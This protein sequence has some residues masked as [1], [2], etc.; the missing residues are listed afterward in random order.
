MPLIFWLVSAGAGAL[1]W[2]A[3]DGFDAAGRATGTKEK[4]DS[5]PSSWVWIG[6]IGLLA[7]LLLKKNEK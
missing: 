6:I 2:V 7:F 4:T 1:G 5:N 3:N